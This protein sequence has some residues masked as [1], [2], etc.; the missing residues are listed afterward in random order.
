MAAL[1]RKNQSEKRIVV[2]GG[3]TGVFTVLTGLRPFFRNL[4]AIVTMADDGGSTGLLREEF[5]I[6]PP[7]DIRRALIALSISDNKILSELFNYRFREGSGLTGH[8]FGNLMITALERVT[9]GFESAIA[10]AA[11]ILSVQGKVVPVTLR[12]VKLMAELADGTVVRGEA[13]I[14]IPSHDGRLKIRRV[15]LAPRAALNPAARREIMGADLVIIGPGDLYTSIVPNLVVDG[16][17]EALRRTRAK[18]LYA[19]NV[20]TKHGETNGYRASDFLAAVESYLGKGAVDYVLMNNVRPS[21]ARL[22]PYIKERAE[23][24]EPDVARS[25]RKPV[26]VT[27]DLIRSRGFVRHDPEKLARVISMLL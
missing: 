2:I 20:M 3:G 23:F 15:W 5:G 21:P 6:L 13:N 11:K 7:G 19:V 4:T 8:N 25:S 12:P 18:K 27:A 17:R 10:E 1:R 16:M 26:P 22:R 24:V 9:G 14:D